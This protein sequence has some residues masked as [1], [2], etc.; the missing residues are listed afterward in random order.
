MQIVGRPE[1]APLLILDDGS[2]SSRGRLGGVLARPRS[3]QPS[4]ETPHQVVDG[5][6]DRLEDGTF[7]S[8]SADQL[9]PRGPT[10]RDTSCAP[11]AGQR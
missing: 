9:R 4:E 8:Q 1:L 6:T 7:K 2:L 5:A 11:A 10:V 3:H